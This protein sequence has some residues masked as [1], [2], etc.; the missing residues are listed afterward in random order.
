MIELY[1]LWRVLTWGIV[2]LSGSVDCL[3]CVEFTGR[4]G[5]NLLGVS[6][7]SLAVASLTGWGKGV[8]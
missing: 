6:L 3:K 5:L 8:A 4:L 1:R 2:V 7:A